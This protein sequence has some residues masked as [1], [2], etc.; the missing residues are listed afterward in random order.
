MNHGREAFI[1]FVVAGGN[2][3]EC[4]DATEEVLD[5]MTPAIHLEVAGGGSGAI[6]FGWDNRKRASVVEFDTQPIDIE[7]LVGEECLEI[8]VLDERLDPDA[9][10]ALARQE[11]KAREIAE[12]IDQHHDLGRQTAARSADGLILSPPLAPVPC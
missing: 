7:G 10:V 4:F 1:G 2:S 11:D 3:A 6:G 8:D 9:V 5:E 12:R